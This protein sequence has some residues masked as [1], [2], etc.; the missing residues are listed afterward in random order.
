M[1]SDA[2]TDEYYFPIFMCGCMC[3]CMRVSEGVSCGYMC[4]RVWVHVCGH[5]CT[6]LL[7]HVKAGGSCSDSS[8]IL[9]E[10]EPLDRTQIS[11]VWLV[12]LWGS[13]ASTI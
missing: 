11:A 5:M 1:V 10:T 8:S 12:L 13:S 9:S 4:T 3:M 2:V 7:I 6:W